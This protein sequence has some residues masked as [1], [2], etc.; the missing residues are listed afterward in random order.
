MR[1]IVASTSEL[2]S[3]GYTPKQFKSTIFETYYSIIFLLMLCF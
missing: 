3:Y 2:D 1:V